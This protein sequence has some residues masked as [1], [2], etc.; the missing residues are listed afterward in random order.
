MAGGKNGEAVSCVKCAHYYVTWD[1]SFPRGCRLFGFK[2]SAQ[3]SAMV[4]EATG[5]RCKNYQDRAGAGAHGGAM[6]K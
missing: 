2:T 5:G 3:P 6:R 4:Y 1:P